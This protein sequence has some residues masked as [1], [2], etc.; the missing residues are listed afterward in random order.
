MAIDTLAREGDMADTSSRFR[1]G[2]LGAG[3]GFLIAAAVF[4]GPRLQGLQAGPPR[5]GIP[6]L[7]LLLPLLFGTFMIVLVA[8][9]IRWLFISGNKHQGRL[10]DLPADFDDWHRRAHAQMDREAAARAGGTQP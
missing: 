7:F 4:T 1:W 6:E 5:I 9:A 3:V 2:L 10:A 8:A